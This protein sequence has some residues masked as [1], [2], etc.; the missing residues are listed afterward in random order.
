MSDVAREPGMDL[1]WLFLRLFG[2]TAEQ[3]FPAVVKNKLFLSIFMERMS[4]TEAEPT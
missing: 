3:R 4:A 1:L 2:A